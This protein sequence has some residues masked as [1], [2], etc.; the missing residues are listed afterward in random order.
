VRLLDERR[1]ALGHRRLAVIDLSEAGAQP[2]ANEDESVWLTFNGE[3]YNFQ[4]LRAALEGHGHRFRSQSD[5]EVIVHAYEEWGDDC[6][7]HLRGIFAFGLWDGSRR[8]LLLARDRLGVKPLYYWSYG[9][10]FAFASQPRALLLHPDFRPQVDL[11]AL[12]HYLA[13]R[14]VPHDLAIYSGMAKLPAAHVAIVDAGGVRVERYW[15]LDYEPRIRSVGE[16]RDLIRHRIANAVRSQLVA[17]VPIGLFLSGGIDSST[18]GSLAAAE[19][20]EKLA[21]FTIG[22]DQP[23]FDE[24]SF[25]RQSARHI[26]SEPHEEE[27]SMEGALRLLPDFVET[28]DEPFFDHSGLPTL[29]VSRLAQRFGRKVVLAGDG[30]DEV[31][32]GYRW[33]EGV[34]D[35]RSAS[36]AE[37][38]R[39]RD[40]RDP[41]EVHFER[42]GLLDG[43]RQAGLLV[44]APDFDAL[45]HW[46]RIIRDDVPAVTALQ[47][48]DL[49]SF[50]VDDVLLKVDHAS[51]ACGVEVRVPFLDHELVETAFRIDAAVIFEGGERKAL[52]KRAAR[53]WLPPRILTARKKGFSVPMGAWMQAGLRRLALRLLP[54]GSLVGRRIFRGDMARAFAAEAPPREAWLLLAAELWARR[55]LE[56]EKLDLALALEGG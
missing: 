48:L 10:G 45:E 8:R 41:L 44:D 14:Y 51:M 21:S 36:L 43:P 39:L 6:V 26:G 37:L 47:L 34:P 4:E 50:L 19:S 29:A 27:L 23:G 22:F 40:T 38:L 53:A 49:Q 31:F 52:L 18:V 3:I 5:S 17:D 32:A 13:Y 25:A 28:Y 46:R 11:W 35:S 7:R 56:G 54:D 15:E 16:A 33:Y 55:W 24:R 12:Q 2:I 1:V 9:R 30:A 20:R 42:V